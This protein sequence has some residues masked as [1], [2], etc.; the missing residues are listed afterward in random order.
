MRCF[1]KYITKEKDNKKRKK[2]KKMSNTLLFGNGNDD[3]DDDMFEHEEENQPMSC[4][5]LTDVGYR[6]CYAC[7]YMNVEA[8]GENE[9]FLYMMKLYTQNASTICKDAIFEKIKAYFDKYV[10]PDLVEIE[11]GGGPPAENWS[12]QCIK[13]HFLKHTNFPT[14]EILIQLRIK[15]ALRTKLADNLVEVDPNGKLVFN[16]N[17]IKNVALLDKDILNLLKLQKD[18]SSMVGYNR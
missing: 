15:R 6:D 18:I 17:N 9:N 11:R 2:K 13:E 16:N 10:K 5:E 1:K 12:I 7:K 8:I 4:E 3:E 14:D